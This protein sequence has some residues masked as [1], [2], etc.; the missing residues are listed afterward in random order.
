MHGGNCA[1]PKVKEVWDSE[2]FILLTLQ[3]WLSKVGGL[4]QTL[5]R[6]CARVLKAKYFPATSL[7]QAS[8][9]N[10]S[11]FTWQSIMKGLDVF[12]IGYIWR[13]GSGEKG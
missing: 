9:K 10:G 13:I 4:S 2:I 12:L 8:L 1:T 7:L 11:S 3:C 6:F 5:I